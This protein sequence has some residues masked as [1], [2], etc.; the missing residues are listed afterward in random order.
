MGWVHSVLGH[1]RC[2]RSSS[3]GGFALP[4]SDMPPL[5]KRLRQ[6]RE[7]NNQYQKRVSCRGCGKVL[8]VHY[9]RECDD[10]QV[11]LADREGKR[12]TGQE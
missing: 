5:C 7:G 3:W 6:S 2:F 9:F 8:F 12:L 10:Q 1:C 11:I 4:Q